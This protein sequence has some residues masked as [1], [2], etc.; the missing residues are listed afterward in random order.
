MCNCVELEFLSDD[1]RTENLDCQ[2]VATAVLRRMQHCGFSIGILH[3]CF[4]RMGRQRC[5]RAWPIDLC[6]FAIESPAILSACDGG[7]SVSGRGV[8]GAN[9]ITGPSG[10]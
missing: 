9:L 7:D 10:V 2:E 4:R 5:F 8:A 1:A 3:R 6:A